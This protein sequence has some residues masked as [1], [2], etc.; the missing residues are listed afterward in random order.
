[1]ASNACLCGA[2]PNKT[3]D[4]ESIYCSTTCA[5]ADSL[6]ALTAPEELTYTRAS[7][8]RRVSSKQE[9][10]VQAS[11]K[12][13]KDGKGSKEIDV[14]KDVDS[15]SSS[16]KKSA[17]RKSHWKKARQMLF[18]S[19]G[20]PEES[21]VEEKKLK[22]RILR[23]KSKSYSILNP[24]RQA[25]S[26]PKPPQLGQPKLK[27]KP[28]TRQ[29]TCSSEEEL[30]PPPLPP[31]QAKLPLGARHKRVPAIIKIPGRDVDYT[32]SRNASTA[33]EAQTTA[34]SANTTTTFQTDTTATTAPSS[35]VLDTPLISPKKFGAHS[36]H[37]S[38]GSSAS[39]VS[40]GS[41]KRQ[42]IASRI[43]HPRHSP[44]STPIANKVE[45]TPV[46]SPKIF[47]PQQRES[48]GSRITN[49][50]ESTATP[51][52]L[53][54]GTV[55]NTGTPTPAPVIS[56]N[57]M[58]DSL[59]RSPSSNTVALNRARSKA[60]RDR[61]K[62]LSLAKS[63]NNLQVASNQSLTKTLQQSQSC[64]TFRSATTSTS[65]QTFE[66]AFDGTN[67]ADY[68]PSPT[69]EYDDIYNSNSHISLDNGNGNEDRV[70]GNAAGI[71]PLQSIREYSPIKESHEPLAN[72]ESP[73]KEAS[74]PLVD[75][76]LDWYIQHSQ[77]Y[78]SIKIAP[79]PAPPV[80][81]SIAPK[82][83]P[84]SPSDPNATFSKMSN[85]NHA[86]QNELEDLDD[87]MKQALLMADDIL[88]FS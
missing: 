6:A 83:A 42:S 31:K 63:S 44:E 77:S 71:M 11:S 80:A 25:R 1:M 73:P 60:L 75:Y 2:I 9:L 61:A 19:P 52:G 24:S 51:T 8:Y 78:K 28:V 33:S 76:D 30:K 84:P 88:A 56:F 17:T 69:W 66:S 20:T 34:S 3:R 22:G 68:S 65:K 46:I 5:R 7:H 48:F 23:R 35:I 70:N 81:Q 12:S 13:S 82:S 32:H 27:L 18:G 37:G 14:N 43:S 67:P 54:L 45:T 15:Q 64:S 10:H 62:R 29:R 79:P 41:H 57:D 38:H 26:P 50:P 21:G 86:E 74:P 58:D 87:S 85:T 47:G 40:C 16:S 39:H 59:V 49:S 53:A 72:K 55:D 4:P 36:T